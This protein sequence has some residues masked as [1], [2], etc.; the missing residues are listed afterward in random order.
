M[1]FNIYSYFIF[2]VLII[3]S[4]VG[5]GLFFSYITN[6]NHIFKNFGY[7]GLLGLFFLTIYSYVSNL[8]IAHNLIHNLILCSLGI[9]SSF[10]FLRKNIYKQKEIILIILIFLILFLSILIFK[11]HDDF[12]YYHFAYSYYLTQS[13]SHIGIGQFN[14]GFKTPSSIF[15]LN[16]LFYL[17]IVKYYMFHMPGLLVMGFANIIF[18]KKILKNIK[19]NS[20][21]FL[22]IYSLLCILFIN[23]FFYRM[24][25]HGTD[26]SAQILI[27]ILL[28]EILLLINFSTNKDSLVK[29]YI[30]I[31]LI[32]SFKAFYI[33]YLSF[34]IP[35]VFYLFKK[36]G[37]FS[38]LKF[39]NNKYF[40]FFVLIIFCVL[41]TNLFNT[42]CLIF[43]VNISCIESLPWALDSQHVLHMNNWYE[44]WSK[45]GA[46]PNFRVENSSEYIKYFNWVPNWINMYFFTKVSDFILGLIFLTLITFL[47]FYS[48][49]KNTLN[50]YKI[51]S[52]YIVL[53]ILF[54][55]WF[56]NH[57]SLRYGGYCLIASLLFLPSSIMIMRKFNFDNKSSKNKFYILIIISFLIFSGRNVFRINQE[58]N[59]YGYKP[60]KETY[61]FVDDKHF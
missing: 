31:G 57:P 54:V 6:T 1:E 46:G 16:S 9:L 44:Q 39:I 38:I 10:Y 22:T 28:L 32:I 35:I 55:E 12:P 3:F 47:T 40:L 42:G 58:I 61:F 18:I 27:F 24:G 53:I 25:E 4:V 5:Y 21:N 56:Y 29:L 13:S 2:Y 30:L 11:T 34:F 19:D 45:A 43:P 26:R 15:Y 8:I 17:P 23:I 52:V 60:I 20:I 50:N 41:I 59:L 14:H 51:F 49:V 33:L 36:E 48:N 7:T 37:I